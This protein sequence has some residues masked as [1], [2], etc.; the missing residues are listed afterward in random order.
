MNLGSILIIT[1]V[2]T[3]L[4]I[5][6][7]SV[8]CTSYHSTRHKRCVHALIS[9][10]PP[11]PPQ[12]ASY[13]QLRRV[14]FLWLRRGV[15]SMAYLSHTPRGTAR[16]SAPRYLQ[17]IHFPRKTRT[18]KYDTMNGPAKHQ[19]VIMSNTR[20]DSFLCRYCCVYYRDTRLPPSSWH[21]YL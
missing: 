12:P 5:I 20:D 21:P 8:L 6:R 13:L 16:P 10:P 15:A 17:G 7:Y 14:L 11:P 18:Y 9:L 4:F 1:T 19:P 3:L 2:S